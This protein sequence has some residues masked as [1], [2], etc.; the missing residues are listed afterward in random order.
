MRVVKVFFALAIALQ[1]GG[2]AFGQRIDYRQAVPAL[3]LRTDTEVAV[4]VVDQRPYVT[5]KRKDPRYVGTLRALYYNPFNVTTL[6]GAP[7]A[8]DLQAAIVSGLQRSGVDAKH[9]LAG[10]QQ[11]EHSGQRLLVVKLAEWKS[12]T[13]MRNRFDYDLSAS[14]Y[15]ERGALLASSQAKWSGPTNNFFTSGSDALRAV[16]ADEQVTDALAGQG[17]LAL[18]QKIQSPLSSQVNASSNYDDCM[19]RVLRISDAQL[20]LQAMAACDGAK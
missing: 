1:L 7:L 15:N 2:C 6:S 18:K 13:Y 3:N 11:A 12:D 4:S 8:I 9:H 19:V 14:V 20:R 10:Q 17:P 16:L 5:A